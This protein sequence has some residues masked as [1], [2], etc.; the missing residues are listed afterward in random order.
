MATTPENGPGRVIGVGGVFFKSP[1]QHQLQ[2]W[3]TKNLGIGPGADGHQFKWRDSEHP[4]VEHC[5]VWSLFPHDS[6]YFD[7]SAA[8]FMIN[9]IVDDLDAVLARLTRNGVSVDPQREDHDYGRF[10]WIYDPD[11]NKIELWEP[12]GPT[13]T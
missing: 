7:P 2:S 5:T 8:P 13:N 9:Y 12:R 10:A 4:E 1:D 11:G 6:K 3:Y